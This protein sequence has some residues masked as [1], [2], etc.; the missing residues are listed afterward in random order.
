MR[1]LCAKPTHQHRKPQFPF[2]AL[3]RRLM[4]EMPENSIAA[5]QGRREAGF[6]SSNPQPQRAGMSEPRWPNPTSRG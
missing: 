5:Q 1:R 6:S 2:S 4:L 3:S